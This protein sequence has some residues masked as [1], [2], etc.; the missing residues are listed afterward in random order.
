MAALEVQHAAKPQEVLNRLR[1]LLFS[2]TSQAP[3]KKAEQMDATATMAEWMTNPYLQGGIEM[4]DKLPSPPKP[5]TK[6]PD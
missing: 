6:P 2:R 5:K 4:V 3:R 1:G